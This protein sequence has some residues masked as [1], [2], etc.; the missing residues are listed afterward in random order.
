MKKRMEAAAKLM[1]KL[2]KL[3][4]ERLCLQDVGLSDTQLVTLLQLCVMFLDI[5]LD[6]S[7]TWI[8]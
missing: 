6:V 3:P 4:K 7:S 1:N 5:F 8:I 2:G